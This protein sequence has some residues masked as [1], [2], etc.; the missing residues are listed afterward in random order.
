[1]KSIFSSRKCGLS[2]LQK[3]LYHSQIHPNHPKSHSGSC[4]FLTLFRYCS[5][6][7]L[8]FCN[9]NLIFSISWMSSAHRVDDF[10]GYKGVVSRQPKTVKVTDTRSSKRM[11]ANLQRSCVY[12]HS[13][14]TSS[15]GMSKFESTPTPTNLYSTLAHYFLNINWSLSGV[16]I[17]LKISQHLAV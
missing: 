12:V 11:I 6:D 3:P 17:C 15:N 9:L 7:W 2:C 5:P 16:N 4:L 10:G 8:I 14:K 1:M 13:S